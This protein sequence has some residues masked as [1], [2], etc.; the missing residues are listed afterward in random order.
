MTQTSTDV[1]VARWKELI[2]DSSTAK[3]EVDA[4]H[5]LRLLFGLDEFNRPLFIVMTRVRP[6]EP[7]LSS[8]VVKSAILL[9]KDGLY[10]LVLALEDG[11]L[12]DVFARLCGDLVRRSSDAR[13]EG[14]ALASVYAGLS[15]WKELLRSRPAHISIEALRGLVGELWYGS[16]I[17]ARERPFDEVFSS[18]VGP[19]GA[20]QD[21]QFADHFYEVK[22]IRPGIDWVRVHSEFQLDG[23]GKDLTLTVV[24]LD[25]A[26]STD[27]GAI[28]L[29]TVIDGIRSRLVPT[30]AASEAFELALGKFDTSF[31]HSFYSST[32]FRV[33]D[34]DTYPV[35]AGFPRLTPAL[36]PRGVSDVE[37]RLTLQSISAYSVDPD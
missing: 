23:S 16:T 11:S 8:E 2:A 14:A 37:Y 31:S 22:S 12:F 7:D 28:T 20:H 9:R 3:Q 5:P 18:W 35:D 26:A 24:V 29:R 27:S 10:S 6:H 30:P 32:W 1:F 19:H 36:L 21:F 4:E 25:D 17:L 15:E 13:S 34:F 33:R